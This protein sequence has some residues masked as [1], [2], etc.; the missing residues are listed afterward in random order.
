M[1]DA[2]PP[3]PKAPLGLLVEILR[4]KATPADLPASPVLLLLVIALNLLLSV[5][6]LSVIPAQDP[7]GRFLFGFAFG[8]LLVWSLLRLWRREARFLQTQIALSGTDALLTVILLPLTALLQQAVATDP[9]SGQA[10]LLSLAWIVVL[11]WNLIVSGHILRSA[12]ELPLLA[13]VALALTLFI[14]QVW[15]GQFLFGMP[16]P[17]PS[18]T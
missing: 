8:L 4:L 1:N 17:P 14:I 9:G 6:Y 13:G 11:V 7:Y 5:Y 2:T 16:A 10:Q 18:P 3:P 15:V 12:L